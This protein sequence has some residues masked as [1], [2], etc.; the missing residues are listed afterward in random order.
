MDLDTKL[1]H[2][3]GVYSISELFDADP[4]KNLDLWI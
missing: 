3:G 1:S 4:N 2:V